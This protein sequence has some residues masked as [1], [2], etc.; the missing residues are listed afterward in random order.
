MALVHGTENSFRLLLPWPWAILPVVF[1]SFWKSCKAH[2][3]ISRIY[4][5]MPLHSYVPGVPT[6]MSWGPRTQVVHAAPP[7]RGAPTVDH[8]DCIFLGEG[9]RVSFADVPHEGP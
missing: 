7:Q 1:S 9:H 2:I 3:H 4:I 6:A 8:H 5:Y